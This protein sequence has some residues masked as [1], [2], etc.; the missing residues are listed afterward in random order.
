MGRARLSEPTVAS[1]GAA[2]ID[3]KKRA[4]EGRPP[5]RRRAVAAAVVVVAVAVVAQGKWLDLWPTTAEHTRAQQRD[6]PRDG[7]PR[8]GLDSARPDHGTDNGATDTQPMSSAQ[9][10]T[11][12]LV[13][14]MRNHGVTVH[15]KLRILSTA[16][17]AS[18]IA[19]ERAGSGRGG[20]FTTEPIKQGETLLHVPDSL[21]LTAADTWHRAGVD[22]AAVAPP[23]QSLRTAYL[24][25]D[26]AAAEYALLAAALVHER[27]LGRK[28]PHWSYI[29]CLPPLSQCPSLPC[30]SA[31]ERAALNDQHAASVAERDRRQLAD[32]LRGTLARVVGGGGG[33]VYHDVVTD[34][35]LLWAFGMVHSRA[36]VIGGVPRLV[37]LVDALNHNATGGS[38]GLVRDRSAPDAATSS[39]SVSGDGGA[40]GADG[41][42]DS[43]KGEQTAWEKI[44]DAV[45]GL[46]ADEEVTWSYK[47]AATTF[48]WLYLYGIVEEQGS[49]TLSVDLQWQAPDM[50]D[51]T[52]YFALHLFQAVDPSKATSSDGKPG[53][54]AL[55]ITLTFAESGLV[56]STVGYARVVALCDVLAKG[57]ADAS[58]ARTAAVAA[59]KAPATSHASL[60][61]PVGLQPLGAAIEAGA[62]RTILGVVDSELRQRAAGSDSGGDDDIGVDDDNDRF[63]AARAWSARRVHVLQSTRRAAEDALSSLGAKARQAPIDLYA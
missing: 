35:E 51:S 32:A 53:S 26:R 61:G 13:A 56:L 1:A 60:V 17:M 62:L 12:E 19:T 47:A 54:R 49:G 46:S 8:D 27:R 40:A 29:A 58:A 20:V 52:S 44:A 30:F 23:P 25:D 37:P 63:R 57:G 42:S 38:V 2:H 6:G 41:T 48:D 4:A 43:R 22:P 31:S 55:R 59:A 5:S 24:H 9:C 16:T 14:W 39:A 34:Q 18:S 50:K 28:S 21:C 33:I 3:D 7:Q 36:F 11:V 15:T 45:G 10:D